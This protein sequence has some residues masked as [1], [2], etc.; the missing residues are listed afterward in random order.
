MRTQTFARLYM[1]EFGETVLFD[2][3]MSRRTTFRAGG[4]VAAFIKPRTVE[5]LSWLLENAREES[6]PVLVMGRGSN[7]LFTDGKHDLA[8]VCLTDLNRITRQGSS[9][10]ALAG[11]SLGSLAAYAAGEGLTGLEF[12]S[13]IPGT[14]G[15][16]VYMNAGAYGGEI[17]DVAVSVTV[18]REGGIAV[19]PAAECGFG[20]RRSVFQDTGD[21]DLSASV[22]LSPGDKGEIRA[23]MAELNQRRNEKQPIDKPSAGSTFKRPQ[24]DYAARLIE[25]AGLKGLTVGGAQV[26]V[27]HAGFVIN[28]GDATASDI[29]ALMDEVQKRVFDLSGILLEPEVKI[30]R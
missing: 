28:T 17:K 19:L 29:L 30:I 14:V 7:L 12:A 16:A 1:E 3:P 11:C 2:E 15:G 13:G 25:A 8:V 9:L 10:T 21:V 5:E 6:V 22:A 24:G 27:K 26:S 18:L 23:R 4:T 20:Y